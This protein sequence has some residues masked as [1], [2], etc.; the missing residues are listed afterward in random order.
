MVRDLFAGTIDLFPTLLEM[1]GVAEPEP[2][3]VQ[4]ASLVPAMADG[5]Y[6][7]RDDVF[8]E[9]AGPRR[10]IRTHDAL[11]TWHGRDTRGELY[12]LANDPNC[13]VNLWDDP[14]ATARKADLIDQ[15]LNRMTQNVDPLPPHEGPW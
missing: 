3:P 9:N 8:I 5:S 11:L 6:R 12:D 13:F 14:G 7:I 4:G 2:S 15:L 1:A 10:T